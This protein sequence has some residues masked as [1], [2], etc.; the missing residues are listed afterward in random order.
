MSAPLV[1]A[2]TGGG[3]PQAPT[4]IRH[5]KENGERAVDVLA[6]DMDPEAA[7]RFLADRFRVIPPAGTSGYKE[8]LLEVLAEE[9]PDV[10][11]NVSGADVRH[12]AG[13]KDEIEAMGIACLCSDASAIDMADNKYNLY[14]LAAGLDGVGAPEFR[15]PKSLDEFVADAEA[16][17]YPSRDLCFKPHVGKGSRG[18][19]ILTE[20]FDRRDLL[21]NH[22]PT[23]R[24]ISLDEFV[25]IFSDGRVFP[26]L[27]LMEVVEGEEIDAMT[28]AYEGEALLTTC[29]TRE[30]H[31]W[32]VIDRGELVHRPKIER[33]VNELVSRIT[34]KYNVSL[35]F[36]DDKVIEINPR[37]STFIF[38][39]ELNEPWLA[40]KLGLGLA[41]PNEVRDFRSRVRF[42]RRMVRFMDQIFFE[43]AGGWSY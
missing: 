1:V 6:L 28:I 4:L 36:I 24:Y 23:A 43:E 37:T 32:G 2:I 17:G 26:E 25:S 7:G 38:Q 31:R 42:G 14:T 30:R 33:A 39:N 22:K 34:L 35:Q 12:I 20:R 40:I 10:L 8:R 29:K 41:R 21:L 11:L 19:R 13:F 16:M 3:A 5:L 15:S 9:R 18:F 27:L